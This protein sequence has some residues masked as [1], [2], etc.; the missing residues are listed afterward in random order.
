MIGHRL[1][2]IAGRHG[3]HAAAALVGGQRRKLDAGAALLERVGDLQILVFDENVGAGQRRQRRRRQ[4]RRAQHVRRRSCGGPLSI[5]A[6]VTMNRPFSLFRPALQCRVAAM[7]AGA[8]RVAALTDSLQIR[9]RSSEPGGIGIATDVKPHAYDPAT[10]PE[11]FE[12]VLARRVV[13]FVIDFVIIAVP[14]VRRRCSSSSS[15]SSPSASAG[16]SFGC[17]RRR[18]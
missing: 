8:A 4:Q 17:C 14:L 7:V 12:G 9:M 11:L 2:V 6:S 16:R 1:G 13:A 3:D 15:A 10:N 18:S 5:S